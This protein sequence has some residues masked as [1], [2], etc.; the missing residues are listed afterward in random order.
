MKWE[1]RETERRNVDW[2]IR[3]KA[4]IVFLLHT[5]REK[6]TYAL[7]GTGRNLKMGMGII[8]ILHVNDVLFNDLMK[9]KKPRVLFPFFLFPFLNLSRRQ[10]IR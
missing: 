4:N 3:L 2:N 10:C 6:H 9:G 5:Q 1:E 8:V 7:R